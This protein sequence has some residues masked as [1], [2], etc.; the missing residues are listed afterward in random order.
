MDV[1]FV[2]SN[3]DKVVEVRR[4]F[5]EYDIQV[6]WSRR[7]LPEPQSDRLQDV[8]A[9]KLATAAGPGRA[10]VVED[11]GLFLDGLRGFPGVYS[12][13]VYDTLGLEGILELLQGKPRRATFRTVAG[14]R[15]GRTTRIAVGTVQGTIAPRR[16]GHNGFGYDPNF[17]PRGSTRTFAEMEGPEK[18]RY[19]H[20]GR[21]IRALARKIGSSEKE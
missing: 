9:A 16:K 8:V 7:A 10:V 19:S 20:R 21:A 4:V 15:R 14:F 11:S 17:V 18:D 6:R 5:R 2:T 3:P 13:Y 1:T 12:R